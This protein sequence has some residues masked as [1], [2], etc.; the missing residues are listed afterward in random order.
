L[1]ELQPFKARSHQVP[2]MVVPD[3]TLPCARS[4]PNLLPWSKVNDL[5]L[6]PFGFIHVPRSQRWCI[7]IINIVWVEESR[8]S[9]VQYRLHSRRIC[10]AEDAPAAA[11]SALRQTKIKEYA[12]S[13][14]LGAQTMAILSCIIAWYPECVCRSVELMKQVCVGCV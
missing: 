12:Y 13:P 11:L 2:R 4:I 1:E 5:E 9:A 7:K 14:L 6:Q 3:S 8:P 10:E